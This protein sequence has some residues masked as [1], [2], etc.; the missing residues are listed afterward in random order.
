M[1]HKNLQTIYP[2]SWIY[3]SP[4]FRGLL[5][6]SLSEGDDYFYIADFASGEYDK[7]IKSGD[8][9]IFEGVFQ[10]D[11]CHEKKKVNTGGIM[12]R[13]RNTWSRVSKIQIGPFG[14]EIKKKED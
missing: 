6:R 12:E 14:I 13:I 10:C 5:N 9:V 3:E 1:E 8:D 4:V 2:I 11:S 7:I